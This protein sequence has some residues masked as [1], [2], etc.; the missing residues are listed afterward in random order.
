M[1]EEWANDIEHTYSLRII[2]NHETICTTIQPIKQKNLSLQICLI[3]LLYIT[4]LHACIHTHMHMG[5][6]NKYRK[7]I[8]FVFIGKLHTPSG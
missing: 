2:N 8:T 4:C 3:N 5:S 6:Y 7:W 1:K